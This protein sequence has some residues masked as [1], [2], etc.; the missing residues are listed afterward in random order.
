MKSFVRMG[1]VG[2]LIA[3]LT[4]AVDAQTGMKVTPANPSPGDTVTIEYC[5]PAYA[6]TV[7]TVTI[8]DGGFPPTIETV[9]IPVDAAGKG[10]GTWVVP[11]WSCASFNAPGVAEETIVIGGG[12]DDGAA[13]IL[14]AL[15]RNEVVSPATA[16][17]CRRS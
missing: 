10:R 7:I 9:D 3:A 17:G 16:R 14:Q 5:N 11:V 8:D 12:G 2:L 1:I 13:T 15:V 6:G 4:G